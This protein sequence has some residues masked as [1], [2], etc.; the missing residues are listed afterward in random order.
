MSR[1][2][3]FCARP[4]LIPGGYYRWPSIRQG[5]RLL[6]GGEDDAARLWEVPTGRY[7]DRKFNHDDGVMAVSFSPSGAL[8]LTASADGSAKL[9]DIASGQQ[10]SVFRHRALRAPRCVQSRRQ[11]HPDREQ[12]WDRPALGRGVR[13]AHRRASGPSRCGDL[14]GSSVRGGDTVLTGSKDK[15]AQL[16]QSA[17]TSRWGPALAHQGTVLAV[18]YSPDLKT[19]ATAS[20]DATARLWDIA[21]GRPLGGAL[22]HGSYVGDLDFTRDGHRLI[23]GSSDNL[24]RIWVLP[25]MLE[26]SPQRLAAWVQT[27]CGM[28]LTSN[29]ALRVLSPQD[30]ERRRQ[31]PRRAR[32]PAHPRAMS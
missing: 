11:E 22:R 13:A 9:W 4:W 26:A 29:E 1:P 10:R 15:T 21:T 7:L 27:L 24:A 3:R 18:A 6:T 17:T 31:R 32:R 19:V 2:A 20:G 14:C 5:T 8:A 30:W 28:E 16:W 25:E 23:T 12:R